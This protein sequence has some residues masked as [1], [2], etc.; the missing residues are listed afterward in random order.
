MC[1]R[2]PINN[3]NSGWSTHGLPIQQAD[4]FAIKLVVNYSKHNDNRCLKNTLHAF[5][6]YLRN[7]IN[8]FVLCGLFVPCPEQQLP[9]KAWTATFINHKI[10]PL[11]SMTLPPQFTKLRNHVN[12]TNTQNCMGW[13][14]FSIIP[15]KKHQR[16]TIQLPHSPLVSRFY[17]KTVPNHHL[18][19]KFKLSIHTN[20][21]TCT[22][23]S[24][25]KS[26]HAKLVT[27]A[28]VLITDK[29]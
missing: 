3:L 10:L 13:Y 21:R 16:N 11:Y 19:Q 18:T 14:L 5:E 9:F 2:K 20:T 23:A 29:E 22:V 8:C 15:I 24:L 1:H 12:Y 27:R 28:Y 6:T 17:T 7:F 4:S 25:N 26:Q